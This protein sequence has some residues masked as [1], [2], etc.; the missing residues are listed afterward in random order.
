MRRALRT[1]L[2]FE[3]HTG[4]EHPNRKAVSANYGNLLRA[5][6]ESPAEIDAAIQALVRTPR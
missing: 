1:L 5:M 4:H 6:G 3:R 2:E